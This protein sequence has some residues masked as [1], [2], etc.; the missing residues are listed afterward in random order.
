MSN[1]Y[2]TSGAKVFDHEQ[3]EAFCKCHT[4]G[5]AEHVADLLNAHEN[6]AKLSALDQLAVD[7]YA[8]GR[9]LKVQWQ[10]IDGAWVDAEFPSFNAVNRYRRKPTMQSISVDVLRMPSGSLVAS[11][12]GHGKTAGHWVHL[13][14]L[15]GEVEV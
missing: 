3:E 11:V 6:R 8:S 1:R 10:Q 7:Y 2:K 4:E 15:S 9:K 14:T 12:H 5:D 13:G